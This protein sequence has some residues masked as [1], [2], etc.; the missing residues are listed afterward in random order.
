MTDRK[1]TILCS[2]VT[3]FLSLISSWLIKIYDNSKKK[4]E[5]KYNE[6][7]RNFYIIWNKIHQGKALNFIDL[8]KVIEKK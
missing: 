5:T 4:K 1:F 3:F 8:K 6:F 7:Y 2:L